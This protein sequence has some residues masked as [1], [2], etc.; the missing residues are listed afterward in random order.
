[1]EF[2]VADLQCVHIQ[3]VA[4]A[5]AHAGSATAQ[6]GFCELCGLCSLL[7]FGIGPSQ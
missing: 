4:R 7:S 1:M 3:I 6:S 2:A 5:A